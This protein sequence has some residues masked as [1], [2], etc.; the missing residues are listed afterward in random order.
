[1]SVSI[2]VRQTLGQQSNK[3]GAFT[4]YCVSLQKTE[5]LGEHIQKDTA[6][7]QALERKEKRERTELSV[8]EIM[9]RKDNKP[10][11]MDQWSG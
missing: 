9:R 2:C 1:M 10:N 4:G 7:Q 3:K 11:L 8:C 6:K 5:A